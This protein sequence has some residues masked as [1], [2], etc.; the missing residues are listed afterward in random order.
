MSVTEKDP[1]GWF[2]V[3]AHDSTTVYN[4]NCSTNVVNFLET[5]IQIY[6]NDLAEK[7]TVNILEPCIVPQKLFGWWKSDKEDVSAWMLWGSSARNRK[8]G[9]EANELDYIHAQMVRKLRDGLSTRQ[10][11]HVNM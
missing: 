7:I 5:D 2:T 6:G 3:P 9:K 11:G 10:G 1:S 8:R 4:G